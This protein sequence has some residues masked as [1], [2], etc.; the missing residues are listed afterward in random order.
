MEKKKRG[1]KPKNAPLEVAIKAGC[2]SGD[3][4]AS[5]ENTNAN[6]N[7]APIILH[8]DTD[9]PQ[10]IH[11]SKTIKM[12]KTLDDTKSYEESFCNYNP[13]VE[14]PGAYNKQD[15]FLSI[16]SDIMNHNVS[17]NNCMTVTNN[18]WSQQT[19]IY[20]FWCC[21][22]FNTTPVGIPVKFTN[23]TFY[24]IGNFCSF[25]CAASYNYEITDINTNVW[26]RFNLLNLMASKQDIAIPLKCA[27]P[28]SCLKI[29]GGDMDIDK[30]RDNSKK[31][32]YFKHTYPMIPL[33]EQIEEMCDSFNTNNT[34]LFTIKKDLKTK[35]TTIKE[36]C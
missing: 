29:F 35:Q 21:H 17:A 13:S 25:E 22:P 32:L 33:C 8:T 36:F 7:D 1:R 15:N 23:K 26:E 5:T 12:I 6:T 24:C 18:E 20:C 27:K 19:D 9:I 16:P 34:E 28:K 3:D 11:M 30:F 31:L 10:I 14:I 2:G 4:D